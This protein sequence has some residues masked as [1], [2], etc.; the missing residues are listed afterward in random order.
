M[1]AIHEELVITYDGYRP[2]QH[3]D[4]CGGD[5]EGLQGVRLATQSH[6]TAWE[7]V[8]E[9]N[10]ET[11]YLS[12]SFEIGGR[13]GGF[14]EEMFEFQLAF[15]VKPTR[16]LSWRIVESRFRKAMSHK[17]DGRL[18]V[19]IMGV[20][21]RYLT[22]RLKGKVNVK[23]E[24][25]PNDL[26]YGLVLVTFV[27]PYPRWCEDDYT[28][29]YTTQVDTRTTGVEEAIFQWSNPTN[30]EIWPKWVLQAGNAGIIYTLPDPSL[31][32]DRFELADEHADRDI[33]MPSLILNEHVVVDTDEMTMNGQ[34]NSS[35]DTAVYQRMNGREFLYPIPEYTD[36]IEV[37]VF[38]EKADIGNVIQLRLPRTW[39][40][41]W[42]LE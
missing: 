22:V 4:I 39:S 38:I 41:P 6:G 11:I 27:A 3:F 24:V 35:L 25:D 18:T 5:H 31:G 42:G 34:V 2:N 13:Y 14:R 1:P 36:P 29:T 26:K 23:A 17:K 10:I 40:R 8:F 21:E 16:D 15:H 32:D 20:S 33:E 28:Q 30:N 7:D 37:S 12:T 19:K 9:A